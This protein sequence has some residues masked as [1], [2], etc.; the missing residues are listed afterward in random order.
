MEV[1]LKCQK[2]GA[3]YTLS[4]SEGNYKKGK[5]RKH[6]SRSCANGRTHSNATKKKISESIKKYYEKHPYP[7]GFTDSGPLK[8]YHCKNCN[9]AF[10][11]KDK[12]DTTGYKYCSNKCRNEFF[13]THIKPNI[14]GKRHGS[15][16]GKRGGTRVSIATQRGNLL[17]L[18]I[19]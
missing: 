15:G 2:C 3:E 5:Y 18:S 4:V 12:R 6:C 17:L 1:T 10:T 19:V 7:F 9:K 14:G 13:K 16:R 8:V 11:F